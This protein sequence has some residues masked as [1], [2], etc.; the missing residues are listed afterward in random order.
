MLSVRYSFFVASKIY[1]LST[2]EISLHH[3]ISRW[4][5][6]ACVRSSVSVAVQKKRRNDKRHA[7][8]SIADFSSFL[9]VEAAHVHA[10]VSACVRDSPVDI[11]SSMNAISIFDS[12]VRSSDTSNV[13]SA[14]SFLPCWRQCAVSRRPQTLY[15]CQHI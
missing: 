12:S 4:P 1:R 2:N 10:R 3:P 14:F 6:S 15:V 13:C 9:F 7:R 5:R 8:Q 11:H